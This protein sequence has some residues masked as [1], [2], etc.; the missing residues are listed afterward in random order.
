MFINNNIF[1]IFECGDMYP[2]GIHILFLII[3]NPLREQE[4]K[5]CPCEGTAPV[6]SCCTPKGKITFKSSVP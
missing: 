2:L 1:T 5:K 6:K 3:I 4:G